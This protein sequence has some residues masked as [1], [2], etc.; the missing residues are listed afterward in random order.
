MI[1]LTNSFIL[2]SK[3]LIQLNILIRIFYF[4]IKYA[5]INLQ[6]INASENLK[7]QEPSSTFEI[8]LYSMM[9]PVVTQTLGFVYTEIY[10]LSSKIFTDLK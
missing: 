10:A 7:S 6:F 4:L 1:I 9:P 5:K 3:E 2:R 8:T